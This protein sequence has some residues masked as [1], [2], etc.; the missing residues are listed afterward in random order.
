M[1]EFADTTLAERNA[2]NPLKQ[3]GERMASSVPAAK[4]CGDRGVVDDLS[5]RE[6]FSPSR[7][8]PQRRK[9]PRRGKVGARLRLRGGV[10]R[11]GGE[12]FVAASGKARRWT[13]SIRSKEMVIDSVASHRLHNLA[14]NEKRSRTARRREKP[15][16][17][18]AVAGDPDHRQPREDDSRIYMKAMERLFRRC[19]R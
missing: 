19:C 13:R 17:D 10:P 16:V 6:R 3:P 8:H 12:G 15:K 9:R 1:R 18:T 5:F 7:R 4:L 14:I 11:G 2:A